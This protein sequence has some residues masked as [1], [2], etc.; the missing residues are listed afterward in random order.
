MHI[1]VNRRWDYINGVLLD[2]AQSVG[3]VKTIAGYEV[4]DQNGKK[5]DWVIVKQPK[6]WLSN[7]DQKMKIACIN[8]AQLTN[9]ETMNSLKTA[10]TMSR[11]DMYGTETIVQYK[12]KQAC[13]QSRQLISSKRMQ[14]L[15]KRGEPMYL[16]LVRSTNGSK[17]GMTQKVKF[18]MMKEKGAIR[19]APPIAETRQHMWYTLGVVGPFLS[20]RIYLTQLSV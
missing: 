13:G 17:Q 4:C 16:A 20:S 12:T 7:A 3:T 19:K 6:L 11:Q 9:D 14:K 2:N 15:L 1:W 18:Q 8:T 10:D 5:D